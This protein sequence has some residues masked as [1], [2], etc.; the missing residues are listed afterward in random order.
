MD[1]KLCENKR[2]SR[3]VELFLEGCNCSQAVLCAQA[4]KVGL[5]EDFAKRLAAPLGG[6]VGRLR[7]VCGAFT[8]CA[9]LAGL[10]YPDKSKEEIYKSV[11][12][13]AEKFKKENG[14]TIICREL[15]K[16]QEGTKLSPKPEERTKE[17]YQK[18]PCVKIVANA[19]AMMD[20]FF[21]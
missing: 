16:L 7:E 8:V 6:G 17:Y 1:D 2:N 5:A 14:G 20:D 9:I 18:R 13:L 11:Q 4:S 10:K 3:A 12:E 21:K 19:S 15:L